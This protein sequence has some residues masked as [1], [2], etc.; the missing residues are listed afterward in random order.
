MASFSNDLPD[1]GADFIGVS[2]EADAFAYLI[3]STTLGPP[4]AIGLFGNW[5]SGKS[6]LMAKIRQRVSQLTALAATG[7]RIGG[8]LVQGRADRVQRLAVRRD[9]PVGCVALAHLRRVVARGA[10]ES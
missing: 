10:P 2:E 4:L 9:G 7:L 6:F 1:P 8:D 3:A 5:G